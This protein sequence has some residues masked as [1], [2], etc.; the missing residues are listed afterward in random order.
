MLLLRALVARFW[1]DAVPGRADPLGH[2]AAR[3]LAAAAFRRRRHPRRRR[4]SRPRRLRV[5]AAVV[6]PV[7]RVPLPALR[8][9][10]LRRRH[11]RAAP[12]DRA[13]ARAGRGDEHR[14][15]GALRRLVG[16]ADAGARSRGMTGG[17]HAVTCNGRALP[18]DADRRARRVRRGRALSRVEPAVGAA[19]DDRRA[20]AAD[21]R[22]RRHCGRSA[23]SAAAR[24]TSRIR[25]GATTRRSR[26]TPTR[27]RRAAS[28][29]S[30]RT[31]TRRGRSP[32][33][34]SRRIR[35]RRRRSTC[36]GSRDPH[37]LRAESHRLPAPRQRPHRAVSVGVRA[38]A[39]RHVHPAHRGH[40]RRALDAGS[41]AGDPRR[42]GVARAR[43]RR[44]SVLPDAADGPLPRGAR[45]PARARPRVSRLHVA[46]TSST[47]CARSSMARGE[48]P[49][50]DGRW[51]PENAEGHDAA[52]RRR[53]G[54]PL[55]QPG[56]RAS[57]P[58]TTR[59]KGRI[60]IANAE[61]DDLVHR[62]RRRHADVQLLRRRRRRRHA[63]HARDPR[64]RPRQQHAAPDQHPARARCDAAGVR[65]PADR[66]R[67]GRRQ[68]VE[69]P[70]RASA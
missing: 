20:G 50:Y 10:R 8:H 51:R 29:A 67:R 4:R 34:P 53:A 70:R 22:P 55:S 11:P 63:H 24:I 26:S 41:R 12:G 48:K 31:A 54:D 44:G 30:G 1:R 38:P 7:R 5:R 39:Q 57:S 59:V 35:R 56:R 52:A 15:H 3:P 58:G 45:R 65:A 69:A 49:R 43:L 37:A 25:A 18:L 46:R 6:R 17:R 66:A 64:R 62:A 27:P 33:I 23:R 32:C 61:L 14:R 60:E 21:V 42:D 13:V 40:R 16:R 36:A 47:R 28:R 19:S 68:A 9:R 2:R